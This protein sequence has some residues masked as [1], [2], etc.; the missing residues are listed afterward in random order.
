MYYGKVFT[1]YT[2]VLVSTNKPNKIVI[3]AE[4]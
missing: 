4:L 3:F 2:S 1:D